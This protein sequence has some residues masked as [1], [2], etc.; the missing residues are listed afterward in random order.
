[1]ARLSEHRIMLARGGVHLPSGMEYVGDGWR[2]NDTLALDAQPA[3]FTA[4]NGGVPALFT[5]YIDPQT[6]KVVYAPQMAGEF[7]GEQQKG[8]W[9]TDTL[10]F[11]ITE[12]A[13]TVSSYG[14][15]N[16][17]GMATANANWVSRQ[18]FHFQTHNIW[19]EREMER[20]AEA[21]VDWA[22]SIN[23]AS[24]ELLARAHNNAGFYGVSGLKIYGGLNDPALP[25]AVSPTTKAAG[26]YTW[27]V[28]TTIEIYNDFVKLYTQLQTQLPALVNMSSKMR[29]GVPNT[30][31]PYLARTNDFGKTV[32]EIIEQSFPNV[33]F[34]TI[35]QFV[36]A[37]GNVLQLRLDEV[38]GQ[39]VSTYAFTE[40]MRLHPV[41]PL[42]SGWKQKKSGG[43][44]GTIIQMPAAFAQM[45]GA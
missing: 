23:Y 14:D 11:P 42:E 13:G 6:I 31:E 39:P 26:G 17:N 19:G 8:S 41:I 22:A 7:Y 15:F 20:Y 44:A 32:R 21:R 36:T 45:L 18:T 25:A 5:T 9:V 27:A 35:P 2:A 30:L 43:T 34:Y 37:S 10:Q 3:L 12:I 4:P 28:G 38:Q 29:F 24:S 40:K 16:Q 33:E 1:M